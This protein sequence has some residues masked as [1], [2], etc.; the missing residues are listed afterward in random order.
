MIILWWRFSDKQVFH[1]KKDLHESVSKFYLVKQWKFC[2]LNPNLVAME[3]TL[4]QYKKFHLHWQIKKWTDIFK[5]RSFAR[6]LSDPAFFLFGKE[7]ILRELEVGFRK[8]SCVDLISYFV[9]KTDKVKY[10]VKYRVIKCTKREI[11]V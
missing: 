1:E 11:Q 7:V 5:R 2:L 6:A 8:T 9:T 4:K 10:W 3:K